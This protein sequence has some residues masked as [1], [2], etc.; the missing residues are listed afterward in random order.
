MCRSALLSCVLSARRRPGR[1]MRRASVLRK[2]Q[3]RL[4]ELR[5]EREAKAREADA[6][7]ERVAELQERLAE[8]RAEREAKAREADAQGERVA[9]LQER[10]AELR[11]EHEAS[12]QL[13][14]RSGDVQERLAEL[15]AEREAKAR[16]ADAQ[17]ERLAE[18]Q[19]RLAELRAEREA[20][21]READAQGER[22]A[23]L[24]ERLAE[25]RAERDACF[26][27]T[28]DG[29]SILSRSL[30]RIAELEE[31]V[32]RLKSDND[33]LCS[34]DEENSHEIDV[35]GNRILELESQLLQLRD[36]N[37]NL[38][39][40]DVRYMPFSHVG[41]L[42]VTHHSYELGDMYDL[43]FKEMPESLRCAVVIDAACACG[44]CC[45]EV[46]V[47]VFS[48]N[49]Y[50][51]EFDVT[52]SSL[53]SAE[54][55]DRRLLLHPFRETRKLLEDVTILGE[56]GAIH[57]SDAVDLM[58]RGGF[59]GSDA[60]LSLA[61][62]E[63]LSR[64]IIERATVLVMQ[65][66]FVFG[67]KHLVMLR[68]RR[69]MDLLEELEEQAIEHTDMLEKMEEMVVL[70][71]EARQA[72]CTARCELFAREE[73]VDLLR[74]REY[75]RRPRDGGQLALRD[76]FQ[77][78]Q[79]DQVVSGRGAVTSTSSNVAAGTLCADLQKLNEEK[80][81]LKEEL[82]IQSVRH[83][84]ALEALNKKIA[85][86]MLELEEKGME[87]TDTV[88]KL[89]E[90]VGLLEAAR[91]AEQAALVT[92]EAREQ[93]LFDLQDAHDE[94]M[95]ELENV[96]H[97]LE[98][99]IEELQGSACTTSPSVSAEECRVTEGGTAADRTSEMFQFMRQKLELLKREKEALLMELEAKNRQHDSALDELNRNIGGLM[100]D[101]DSRIRGCQVS[102]TSAKELLREIS[103]LRSVEEDEEDEDESNEDGAVECHQTPHGGDPCDS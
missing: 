21:A 55:I 75:D 25:L 65:R 52:H 78:V 50:S 29:A 96:V 53:I 93:E 17:G 98:A 82:E 62:D 92:L 22:V 84:E 37:L 102:A 80:A 2:L 87:Y 76:L 9:E 4:A 30:C 31:C 28:D 74:S 14:P 61:R 69:E 18:L 63:L 44:V 15:R 91:A 77:R 27:G 5:A 57:C 6:Q 46:N 12:R 42:V 81:A 100:T 71:E 68:A 49:A 94:E 47:V 59:R 32:N 72:E 103:L 36:E 58:R 13:E 86:L 34:A 97:Q 101:L 89:E 85:G 60:V 45:D 95:R 90:F 41:D 70:L 35:Q 26:Q 56:E 39:K 38:R 1:L 66:T 3:E 79:G 7:G 40:N 54:E 10:L 51:V 19:E 8:L 24:Q 43:L 33:F 48:P 20:K 64:V 83:K 99:R 88:G 67:F 11:A 73:M 16:E 23:E